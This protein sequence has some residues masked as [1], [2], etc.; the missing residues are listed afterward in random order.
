MVHFGL[1]RTF[2]RGQ[3]VLGCIKV[4]PNQKRRDDTIRTEHYSHFKYSRVSKVAW[5]QLRLR[6]RKWCVLRSN[7]YFKTRRTLQHITTG[8]ARDDKS[9]DCLGATAILTLGNGGRQPSLQ[10]SQLVATKSTGVKG[11]CKYVTVNCRVGANSRQNCQVSNF[12]FVSSLEGEIWNNR[13]RYVP[14]ISQMPGPAA[15]SRYRMTVLLRMPNTHLQLDTRDFRN[16]PLVVTYLLWKKRK[17]KLAIKNIAP[18]PFNN[19]TC[20]PGL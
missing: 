1:G 6:D 9:R 15:V 17:T 3:A 7:R 13:V 2:A 20:S 4:L 8:T 11:V 19:I 10:R 5:C 16:V 14:S 18:F 12:C